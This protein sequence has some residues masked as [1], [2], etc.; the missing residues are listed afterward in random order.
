MKLLSL[1]SL[2]L[3]GIIL[4]VSFTDAYRNRIKKTE[5]ATETHPPVVIPDSMKDNGTNEQ[6]ITFPNPKKSAFILMNV[7]Y[8]FEVYKCQ[9]GIDTAN[10]VKKLV[11]DFNA[12]VKAEN[13][14]TPA[15]II[16]NHK[17]LQASLTAIRNQFATVFNSNCSA[18][19]KA[20]AKRW[21][22]QTFLLSLR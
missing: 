10:N 16:E 12:N 17:I 8:D 11:M 13:Q 14:S 6:T 18:F 2:L 7:L 4:N 9:P 19:L 20:E 1:K 5:P 21:R 3:L 22:R 15:Q